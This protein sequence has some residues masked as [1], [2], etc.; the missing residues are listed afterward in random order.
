[1]AW[2]SNEQASAWPQE[3]CINNE[4]VYD[5]TRSGPWLTALR[6]DKDVREMKDYYNPAA[7]TEGLSEY[8]LQAKEKRRRNWEKL[9]ELFG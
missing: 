3:T 9:R 4:L 5:G 1:M 2:C 6:R 8:E 7:C